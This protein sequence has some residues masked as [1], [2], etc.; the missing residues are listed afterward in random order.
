MGA[1]IDHQ[2]EEARKAWAE[3]LLENLARAPE[4]GDTDQL[5]GLVSGACDVAVANSYYFARAMA[6]PVEGLSER[7]T[8][9]AG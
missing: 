9:S 8:R 6:E 4:G 1:I 5:N 7:W 3:G 2:G